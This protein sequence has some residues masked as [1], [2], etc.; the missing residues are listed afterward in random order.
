MERDRPPEPGS[1][2]SGEDDAGEFERLLLEYIDRL[3]GGEMLDPE[4]IIR[5][6]PQHGPDLVRHLE[7]FH[8]MVR[9]V[10]EP[11]LGTLGDYT[12]RRQIGRGGMGIVYEAWQNSVD[13]PVAL[14]V[15]PA[16]IAADERALQRFVREAKTAAQL[17]HPHIV[18]VHGMG[19]ERDTPYYAM[20]FVEGETLARLLA[21]ARPSFGATREELAFYSNVAKAFAD[22][23]DG[24]Q[25]AHARRVIHRDIKPSNLILDRGGRLRILDFGLARLEGQESLTQTGD[26]VGTPLYM[27]PEQA[28]VRKI[29]ID[30]R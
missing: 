23:A 28:Q 5:T 19:V 2:A 4:R 22:V 30:H 20:E 16:G 7:V 10:P 13:R 17:S 9:A 8:G 6:H 21:E 11:V 18:G 15:L 3:N 14:K 27:S 12:L 29:P 25:H 26:F 24:L 1:S